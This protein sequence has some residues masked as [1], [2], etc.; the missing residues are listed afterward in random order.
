[1]YM[2]ILFYIIR[3]DILSFYVLFFISP[4]FGERFYT[5]IES[6]DYALHSFQLEKLKN[7]T[8]CSCSY[9]ATI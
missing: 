1:M 3:N 5:N 7:T 8:I 2:Y 4:T 9:K 6:L